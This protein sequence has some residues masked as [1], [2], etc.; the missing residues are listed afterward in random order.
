MAW[1]QVLLYALTFAKE[2][3]KYLREEG[4]TSKEATDT[5]KGATDAIILARKSKDTSKI[6]HSFKQLGITF[7]NSSNK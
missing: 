7:P 4:R 1:I 6:E 5:I 2:V 3:V